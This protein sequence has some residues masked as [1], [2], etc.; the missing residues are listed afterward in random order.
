[1][2]NLRRYFL[3]ANAAAILTVTVLLAGLFHWHSMTHVVEMVE[4]DNI[5]LS[6]VFTN[7]TRPRFSAYVTSTNT[8]DGNVLRTR[9]ETRI[10]HDTLEQITSGLPIVRVRIFNLDGLIV[11][12]SEPSEMGTDGS[13]NP[14][15]LEAAREGLPTSVFPY[16]DSFH[17]FFDTDQ[18]VVESYIPIRSSDGE[19]EGILE[20][21]TD[22]SP[23]VMDITGG[24][25][26][27]TAGLL[28]V[29]GLLYGVLFLIVQHADNILRRQYH[30]LRRNEEAIRARNQ[31]LK[32][33]NAERRR[34][35]NALLTSEQML[36]DRVAELENARGNLETQAEI[37][38]QL[39]DDLLI[40]RDEAQSSDRAK[41]EF[42]AAMSHELRTPLNAIIGFSDIIKNEAFGPVGDPK[43]QTFTSDIHDAGQHLLGLINEILDLSKIESG[44][45]EL[46]EDV[47]EVPTLAQSVLRLMGPRAE[48]RGVILA[49]EVSDQLPAL[50]A[51]E[52]KIRQILINL[53]SNSIKFTDGGGMVS[54]RISC[55]DDGGHVFEIV[56]TGI[57]ISPQDIPKALSRFG[58]V[59]GDLNRHY[60]GTG[61]GL[62][63]SV[64]LVELHGGVFDIQSELGVG[65]TV[66]VRMPIARTVTC[67][68]PLE[69]EA[70][71]AS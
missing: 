49:L 21:Y 6:R 13:H 41:S 30:G 14:G 58:Q 1:M 24:T 9:P 55:D 42:L 32:I 37:L 15:Y 71:V 26:S 33:E 17:T 35:E 25:I 66:T 18:D 27:L 59:E 47:I 43:Y 5:V 4:T 38:T 56:D 19:I 8:M 34:A 69:P 65:T 11:Y 7:M 46:F 70:R 48:Q 45:D 68:E 50:R 29:L 51:D 60:E 3:L 16:R 28:L 57:G 44:K 22:V 52:R 64:A 2:F 40:A 54:L 63:L 61:L 53:L 20:I 10:I 36:Q 67:M 39:T 62:P 12:S 31:E 23:M